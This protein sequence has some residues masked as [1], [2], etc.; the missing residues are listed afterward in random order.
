VNEDGVTS[1]TTERHVTFVA[2]PVR[3]VVQGA[4]GEITLAL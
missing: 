2:V 3:A 4:Q 1:E